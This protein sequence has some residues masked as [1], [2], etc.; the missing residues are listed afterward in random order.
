LIKL[1]K[2]EKN[3]SY[4]LNVMVLGLKRDDK[5]DHVRPKELQISRIIEK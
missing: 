3:D 5:I 2:N 4:S 1:S